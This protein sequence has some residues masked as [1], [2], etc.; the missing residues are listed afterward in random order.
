MTTTDTPECKRRKRDSQHLSAVSS[1]D[2]EDDN[3]FRRPLP[4]STDKSKDAEKSANIGVIEARREEEEKAL[5]KTGADVGTEPSL[6]PSVP[7]ITRS[8]IN[9]Y[10][11]PDEEEEEEEEDAGDNASVYS[12]AFAE[13]ERKNARRA[14]TR[15]VNVP[16]PVVRCWGMRLE[17]DMYNAKTKQLAVRD[18]QPKQ[19]LV[20][21]RSE[22]GKT[23][24]VLGEYK[25]DV[26][27]MGMEY[28]YRK[29]LIVTDARLSK[30]DVRLKA[31]EFFKA[32]QKY[33]PSTVYFNVGD[34]EDVDAASSYYCMMYSKCDDNVAATMRKTLKD[35]NAKTSV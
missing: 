9:S 35:F 27:G 17:V 18:G 1:N 11:E 2:D 13:E 14:S 30:K 4:V 34:P 5:D 3:V 24:Y 19:G 28:H 25:K 33:R 23:L 32:S 20:G 12:N 10:F 22:D 6:V 15:N 21:L 8:R 16:S 29:V 7:L 26:T 31:R